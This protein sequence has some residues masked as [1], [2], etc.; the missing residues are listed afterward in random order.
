MWLAQA[1][2][3]LL[4]S[5]AEKQGRVKEKKYAGGSYCNNSATVRKT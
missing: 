4:G 1:F 5:H 3:E 2:Q